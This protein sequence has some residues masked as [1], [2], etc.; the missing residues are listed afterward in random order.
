MPQEKLN[1]TL[2]LT[3]SNVSDLQ[4]P[5]IL[6][7]GIPTYQRKKWLVK[8]LILIVEQ[9]EQETSGLIEIVV[10]DNASTDGTFEWLEGYQK[11]HR[12]V[13]I[14]RHNKNIGADPNFRGLP[15]LCSGH[16]FWLLGDDDFVLPSAIKNVLYYIR[17][18][19]DYIVLNFTP[20]VDQNDSKGKPCWKIFADVEVTTI[21]E[22]SAKIPN[23]TFGFISCWVAKKEL[24]NL[25]DILVSNKYARWGMAIYVDRHFTVGKAK[26]GLIM[27]EPLIETRRPPIAATDGYSKDFHFF[28][29]FFT[30]TAEAVE[31]FRQED[32]IDDSTI[33]FKKSSML[34][35]LAPK[36]ILYERGFNIFERARV[37]TILFK[38]YRSHWQY[39]FLCLP[40]M[41]VPYLGIIARKV[42]L[43]IQFRKL[44]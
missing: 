31:L 19:Y 2:I 5:P 21:K 43:I 4:L 22:C 35:I 8:C 39:W 18:G 20:T 9:V 13:K 12:C 37:N 30:G 25:S 17:R 44:K 7:I 16:Y 6:S 27:A 3:G 1:N 14:F 36:R 11:D 42:Q 23:L 24:F 32:M 40:A 38:Y 34:T 28:E 29:W 33:R 15:K 10:S 41:Y 26:V